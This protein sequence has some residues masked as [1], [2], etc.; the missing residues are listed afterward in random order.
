MQISILLVSKRYSRYVY[1]IH[2]IKHWEW[3]R[4]HW[5]L[6]VTSA[7]SMTLFQRMID[8]IVALATTINEALAAASRYVEIVI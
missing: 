7:R 6:W 8:I 2:S 1:F 5:T 3:L 4:W